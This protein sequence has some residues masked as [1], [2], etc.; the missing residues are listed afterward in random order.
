MDIN[1][2]PILSN[3]KDIPTAEL[4]RVDNNLF[5]KIPFLY[6]SD[7]Y[8]LGNAIKIGKLYSKPACDA[9]T[10]FADDDKVVPVREITI[11]I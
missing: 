9:I 4:F 11:G 7:G 2:A 10:T 5:V 8:C 6:T 1:F 3:F